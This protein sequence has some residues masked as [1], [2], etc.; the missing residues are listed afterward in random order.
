MLPDR[1]V[2]SLQEPRAP[3]ASAVALSDSFSKSIALEARENVEVLEERRRALLACLSRLAPADRELIR[4]RYAPS[5]TGK[6][7]ARKL[8]RPANSVYQSLSRIRR[9]LL[10]CV[11]RRM[12]AEAQT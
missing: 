1:R 8:G 4:Q 2:G 3:P 11:K 6:S 9:A 7:L 12:A 10:E 5:E